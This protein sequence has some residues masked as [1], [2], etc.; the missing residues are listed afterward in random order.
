M[1]SAD[2][3]DPQRSPDADGIASLR[4]VRTGRLDLRAVAMSDLDLIYGL[5]SDPRVWTHMPSG[6]HTKREQ[7]KAQLA[8]Q[9]A[10]WD[11][12][13][14]AQWTARLHDG[15]FAGIGG[16]TINAGAAWNVY[17]RFVP[18]VHGRG[19]ATELVQTAQVAARQVRPDLPVTALLLEHNHA[20]K[21]VAEKS[22]LQ[23]VWRGRDFGNPDPDAIR[24]VYAD[25]DVAPDVVQT[26]LVHLPALGRGAYQPAVSPL[27][28]AAHGSCG[29]RL[30]PRAA[31][32]SRRRSIL[33]RSPP[34]RP[35]ASF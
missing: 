17:Y 29:A 8:R 24:L 33:G 4:H 27:D 34:R 23:L 18:E 16:C 7:T 21:A 11:S 10:A 19:L 30:L 22:G 12:G 14:L 3:S 6:V 1:E 31:Q 15:T 32:S 35:G 5:T 2:S 20:S 9:V 25:R 26:L 13:G 28:V